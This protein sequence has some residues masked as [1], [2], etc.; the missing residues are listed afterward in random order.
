VV[1]TIALFEMEELKPKKLDQAAKELFLNLEKR[2]P[3]AS[4]ENILTLLKEGIKQGYKL[5]YHDFHVELCE[6]CNYNRATCFGPGAFCDE[7]SLEDIEER[8]ARGE[9]V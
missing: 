1:V 6:K 2:K 4:D 9:E 7:C 5:G 8:E 3:K